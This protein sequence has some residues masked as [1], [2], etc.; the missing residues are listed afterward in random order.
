MIDLRKN[1][2]DETEF[3]I[4]SLIN[5]LMLLSFPDMD[6]SSLMDNSR[7]LS[8]DVSNQSFTFYSN[9]PKD[10]KILKEY[11]EQTKYFDLP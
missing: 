11:N 6:D 8:S 7:K 5:H 9:G 3:D 1:E 2:Y 10:S 4:S